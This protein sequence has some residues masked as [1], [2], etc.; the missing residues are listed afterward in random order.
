MYGAA[1]ILSRTVICR[2]PVDTVAEGGIAWVNGLA[3]DLPGT[4][5]TRRKPATR[6][7]RR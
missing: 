7:A 4:V 1:S 2:T 6:R 3:F 5:R